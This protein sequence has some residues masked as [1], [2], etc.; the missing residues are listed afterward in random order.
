MTTQKFHKKNEFP[1]KYFTVEKV[2]NLLQFDENK[3]IG[4]KS[5]TRK[6][7]LKKNY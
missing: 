3:L 2:K 5:G 4:S 7:S 1:F 6:H